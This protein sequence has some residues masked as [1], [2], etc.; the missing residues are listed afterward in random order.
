MRFNVVCLITGSVHENVGHTPKHTRQ[1]TAYFSERYKNL[2]PVEKEF[3]RERLRLYNNT[4]KRKGSKI[5]YIRKHR[6]LLA[7]ENRLEG[8]E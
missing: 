1:R 5:E 7:D 4:P 2:T 6:A 8:G 3:R